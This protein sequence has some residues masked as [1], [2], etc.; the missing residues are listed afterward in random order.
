MSNTFQ[1]G[2]TYLHPVTDAKAS[3]LRAELSLSG[4][5]GARVRKMPNG[6]C[7]IVLASAAD[8]DNA[9]DALVTV[10]ACTG[11]GKPFTSPDSRFA[12]NGPTEIF[13]RF[14]EA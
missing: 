9:R 6:A 4:V 10:N 7:R 12:W 8:R 2:L 13:I 14:L 1:T 3:A 11:S 5:K